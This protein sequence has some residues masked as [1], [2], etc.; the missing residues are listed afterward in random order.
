M[1][2]A[3]FIALRRKLGLS[4]T[5]MAERMGLRL[6]GLQEIESAN[7]TLRLIHSHAAEIVAL[8]E[9]VRQGDPM[10]AAGRVRKLALDLARIITE[11]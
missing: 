10:L 6:R 2:K 5:A 3:A 4:Q 9:A 1:D 8:E 7:G 11:D